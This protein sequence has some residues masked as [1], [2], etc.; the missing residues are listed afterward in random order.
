MSRYATGE[1]ELLFHPSP[2][3][4]PERR[5]TRALEMSTQWLAPPV[6]GVGEVV[7]QENKY[8]T[9]QIDHKNVCDG[10]KGAH[11]KVVMSI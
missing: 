2:P 5:E 9:I 10:L 6:V 1:G 7:A 3:Q 4:A 11:F 8:G